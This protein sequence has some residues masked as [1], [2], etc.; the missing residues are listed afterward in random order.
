[1]EQR[2]FKVTDT[3]LQA[4]LYG[5]RKEYDAVKAIQEKPKTPTSRKA[6]MYV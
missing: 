1:M 3:R 2:R 5:G 6:A 4:V